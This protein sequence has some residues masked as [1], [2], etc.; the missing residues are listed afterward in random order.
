MKAPRETLTIEIDSFMS[1]PGAVG[2]G[3]QEPL[4]L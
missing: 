4:S 2:L 3:M 1:N